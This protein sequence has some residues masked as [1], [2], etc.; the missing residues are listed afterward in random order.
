VEAMARA[1]RAPDLR[2]AADLHA[3]FRAARVDHGQP[4]R[5]LFRRRRRRVS[6]RRRDAATLAPND[7]AAATYFGQPDSQSLARY[8]T[9]AFRRRFASSRRRDRTEP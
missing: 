1:G 5:R 2:H 6:P 7:S 9:L 3:R 8:V 4:A